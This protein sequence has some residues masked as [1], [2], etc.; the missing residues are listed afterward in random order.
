MNEAP[1][2]APSELKRAT[3]VLTPTSPEKAPSKLKRG[4]VNTD[5]NNPTKLLQN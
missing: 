1:E 3:S 4:Y 2:K 5:N